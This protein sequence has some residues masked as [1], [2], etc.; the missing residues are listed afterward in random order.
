MTPSEMLTLLSYR[1]E[2][3][4]GDY[5]DATLKTLMINRAQVRVISELN[6]HVV[7]EL[8]VV[9][10]DVSLTSGAFTPTEA[11]DLTA[12]PL[13]GASGGVYAVRLVDYNFTD[14]MSFEEYKRSVDRGVTYTTSN[15]KRYFLN[16]KCYILP[17]DYDVDVYYYKKPTSITLNAGVPVQTAFD[18]ASEMVQDA[19]AKLA[20]SL[21]WETNNDPRADVARSAAYELI[22]SMNMSI[23]ATESNNKTDEDILDYTDDYI[24]PISAWEV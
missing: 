5:Y 10:E 16:G 18:Y 22:N 9:D 1:L 8:L 21:C 24:V 20:E 4:N 17:D 12:T 14:L 19:V 23:S 11:G 2:D 13:N 15:P 7:P 3:P 6:K